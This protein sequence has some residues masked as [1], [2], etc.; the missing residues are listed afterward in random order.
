VDVGGTV[1][2]IA[3]GESHTC[4]VL[5]TGAVR[6]WGL[7]GKGALG[8]GNPDFVGKDSPPSAAG[9]VPVGGTVTQVA[10]GYEHTC[11]VL[12]TGAVRCWG[13]ASGG[14]L[15]YGNTEW[16][17]DDETPASAGDV[18][19]GGTAT[20]IVTGGAHTC[21]VLDTGAVRCWGG[22]LHGA[23]GYGNAVRSLGADEVPMS[24]GDVPIDRCHAVPVCELT[25]C[26]ADGH[27]SNDSAATASLIFTTPKLNPEGDRY[28]FDEVNRLFLCQGEEDWYRVPVESLG[29]TRLRFLVRL[30]HVLSP[31]DCALC[32]TGGMSPCENHQVTVDIYNAS[33]GA[34]IASETHDRGHVWIQREDLPA[35]DLLLRVRG[36]P[37]ANM[38]YRLVLHMAQ[39]D[40]G[41]QTVE[42]SFPEFCD[43]HC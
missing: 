8:Y 26:Q 3:A 34:L 21:A 43:S 31:T 10:A 36:A 4:A 40:P 41:C 2:Q 30:F 13:Y 5:D 32:D 24:A 29:I 9:D 39:W 11:A 35:S 20:R 18:P 16:I 33:T 42:C 15:G 27:E 6:C 12:D 1:T 38:A 28:Y 7:G 22:N 37:E 14:K 23:L 25:D 19:V 17:G